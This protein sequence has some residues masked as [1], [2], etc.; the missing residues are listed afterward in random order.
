MNLSPVTLPCPIVY[1]SRSQ[2][3]SNS[4]NC[5][6]AEAR[7]ETCYIV[8]RPRVFA[9]GHAKTINARA[10]FMR[11]TKA[12]SKPS[13]L[14][15]AQK[16]HFDLS[17]AVEVRTSR[18]EI[19]RSTSASRADEHRQHAE[20]LPPVH[21]TLPHE[22][23]CRIPSRLSIALSPASSTPASDPDP[24]SPLR[25]V[26]RPLPSR[27]ASAT[28]PHVHAHTEASAYTGRPPA[29]LTFD[30]PR[31]TYIPSP[32]CRRL[33]LERKIAAPSNRSSTGR[34]SGTGGNK[35]SAPARSPMASPPQP[36]SPWRGGVGD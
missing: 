34:L 13:K 18:L 6:E 22:W 4:I 10:P 3:P 26:G 11:L 9:G 31:A 17:K 24:T 16:D 27:H 32:S 33:R 36:D 30:T 20:H 5:N 19:K 35:R 21:P 7:K 28:N 14:P 25:L 12:T 15:H 23:L 8:F 29:Y 2:S 1:S